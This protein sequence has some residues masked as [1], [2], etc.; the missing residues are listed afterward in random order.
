MDIPERPSQQREAVASESTH[1]VMTF[2]FQSSSSEM[3]I[4]SVPLSAQNYPYAL[5]EGFYAQDILHDIPE[6]KNPPPPPPTD[7][8]DTLMTL[9]D[10]E[11]EFYIRSGAAAA[12]VSYQA[13]YFDDEDLYGMSGAPVHTDYLYEYDYDYPRGIDDEDVDAEDKDEEEQEDS[14]TR[15]PDLRAIFEQSILH[16][17][18]E[19]WDTFEFG[20]ID[21]ISNAQYFDAME[22]YERAEFPASVYYEDTTDIESDTSGESE[23][24][25]QRYW[26]SGCMGDGVRGVDRTGMVLAGGG[27]SMVFKPLAGETVSRHS[28]GGR[29]FFI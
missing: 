8:D 1:P 28:L 17:R 9:L 3:Q 2:G 11:I 14:Y 12:D 16:D 21:E 10:Q 19:K 23:T 29:K 15:D 5:D 24:E 20:S 6:H 22:L 27:E 25:Y 13:Q 7:E 4:Y 26:S 18:R